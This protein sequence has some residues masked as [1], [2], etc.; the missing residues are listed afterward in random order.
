[1]VADACGRDWRPVNPN[2]ARHSTLALGKMVASG[3]VH[4][5]AFVMKYGNCRVIL[6][7]QFCSWSRALSVGFLPIQW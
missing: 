6:N 3:L 1:M 2:H 5:T 7:G 4:A